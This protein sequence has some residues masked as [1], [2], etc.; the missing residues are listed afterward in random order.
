MHLTDIVTIFI[1]REP[2]ERK[3]TITGLDVSHHHLNLSFLFVLIMMPYY[4]LCWQ[5]YS[6]AEGGKATYVQNVWHGNFPLNKQASI[7]DTIPANATAG[8]YYY[9]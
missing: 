9:R 4:V 6:V 8:L 2:D 1:A 3:K 5:L 7:S